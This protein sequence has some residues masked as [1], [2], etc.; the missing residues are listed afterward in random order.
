MKQLCAK[1]MFL[2]FMIVL[3]T[4]SYS[5]SETISKDKIK[6]AVIEYRKSSNLFV[7]KFSNLIY[8]IDGKEVKIPIFRGNMGDL[9]YDDFLNY[10]YDNK[11]MKKEFCESGF[12]I[13]AKKGE[14][15]KT[16]HEFLRYYQN[17]LF[18]DAGI[19]VNKPSKI[20]DVEPGILYI[21]YDFKIKGIPMVIAITV[22]ITG[23][24]D[25]GKIKSVFDIDNIKEDFKTIS[26]YFYFEIYQNITSK[27]C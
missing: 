1:T 13:E 11:L 9:D 2:M 5:V 26:P 12:I 19:D 20:S 3:L 6:D 24:V 18:K 23:D 15:K 27:D 7:I 10:C 16:F 4:C 8:K 21:Y 14:V 17:N 22:Y 25:T